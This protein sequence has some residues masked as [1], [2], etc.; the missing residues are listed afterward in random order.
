MEL[1]TLNDLSSTINT[2]S[3]DL[4]NK[5]FLIHEMNTYCVLKTIRSSRNDCSTGYDKIPES[6]IKPVAEKFASPLA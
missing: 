4:Q 5:P 3:N 6:L 1:Q 2:L